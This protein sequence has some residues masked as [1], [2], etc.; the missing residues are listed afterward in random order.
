MNTVDSILHES[1]LTQPRRVHFSNGWVGHIPFSSWLVNILKPEVIV[2]LGT[3]CG[4]SYLAFC[5]AVQ[6]NNLDTKC[7]AVDTWKGDENAGYYGEEVFLE[8]SK[9]HDNQ[10]SAFSR[11]L[12]MTFDEGVAYFSDGS[13]DLL[14]IDGLHSYEAV[15]HDF[16]NWLPKVSPRGVILFHD[17]NVRER[18]FGVWKLW[19]ELKRDRP[20]IEFQHSHGLGALFVGKDFPENLQFLVQQFRDPDGYPMLKRLFAQLGQVISHQYEIGTLDAQIVSLNQSVAERDAQIGSL[21]QSVSERDAHIGSLNHAVAEL[22]AQIVGL[23]Q[24]RSWRV[25]APLRFLGRQCKRLL[26]I[27]RIMPRVIKSSG[28]PVTTFRKAVGVIRRE[29][30]V[31][32]RRRVS[33]IDNRISDGQFI[34]KL[35]GILPPKVDRYQAWLEVNQWNDRCRHQLEYRLEQCQH[36]LP[37]ISIITPVYNP[38]EKFLE[39]MIESVRNQVYDNWELC[40]ADDCSSNPSVLQVLRDAESLDP[41]IRV[42]YRTENGGISEATNT[43]AKM[44]SGKI[45]VLLDHDDQ[46]SPNA[47]AEVAVCFAERPEVDFLYTDHDKIDDAG[48]FSDPWFKPDWSPELLLSYCYVGHLK[49]IRKSLYEEIGGCRNDFDGA[50]DHDLALRAT[51]RARQVAHIPLILYHWAAAPGSTASSV[52]AKNYAHE[53]GRRAVVEALQRRGVVGN[54]RQPSW[55][56]GCLS[57]YEIEFPDNGHSV[58]IIIPTKNRIHLLKQCISSLD[59]TSYK[60]YSILIVDN[61]SDDPDVIDYL[62]HSCH[63]YITVGSPDGGFNFSYINNVAVKHAKSDL[64]LFLNNDTVVIEPKWLSQM[65]GYASIPGVGAVGARLLFK[66]GRIQ[67]CGVIH[68]FEDRALP[69]H[70]FKTCAGDDLGYMWLSAVARNCLAVTAACMLTPRSL[71]LETGGFDQDKLGTSY[72]DA[73][74]CMRLRDHGYRTVFCSQAELYHYEN[75]SRP[76]GGDL[77]ER[78]SFVGLHRCRKDPFFNP[79][80]SREFPPNLAIKPKHSY[81]GRCRR[82]RALMCGHN[83]NWEGAPGVQEQICVGLKQRGVIDPVVVSPCDGPRRKQYEQSMIGVRLIEFPLSQLPNMSIYDQALE[84][85]KIQFAEMGAEVIYA[86]TLLQ[87][88]V[89]EMANRLGIPT[90]WNIHESENPNSYFNFLLPEIRDRAYNC[91]AYPYRVVFVADATRNLWRHLDSKHNFMTIHNGLDEHSLERKGGKWSR[92]NARRSLNVDESE[93]VILLLGT[94]CERKG[95]QDLPLALGRLPKSTHEKLKCFIVGDRISQETANYSSGLAK[96]VGSLPVTLRRRTVIIPETADIAR[97]YKAADIFV[98]TSRIESYPLVI[99]EAMGYGLP[100]V[101]TPVYG[102]IEQVAP[103]LNSLIYDPGNIEQL[104]SHLE[105]LI[106]DNKLLSELAGNSRHV[107]EGLTNHDEMIDLYAEVFR[108]AFLTGARDGF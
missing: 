80:L 81:L 59:K 4:D 63:E 64:V 89:V 13:I 3:Y 29:G 61:Q 55:A 98:C 1:M 52:S 43:A 95:Q 107:L 82:F 37:K 35:D 51:E 53:A 21:N 65:V 5:Q 94:V 47:L 72:Q 75:S 71:F 100:I 14:H 20:S 12:R 79:N 34:E 103:N 54:V 70:A 108:E 7:Y 8:L 23:I 44:A 24:S 18:E 77:K 88:Y 66:D 16:E 50:Q 68:G 2:E 73:D 58:T 90:I 78:S 33:Q 105:R 69:D 84:R 49:A 19:E 22:D 36:K 17:I 106:V 102:I 15:K 40:L 30:L 42:V 57:I 11:L 25:T 62:N 32:L 74:Y 97:Y 76:S 31:G 104:A 41:R 27:L 26:R 60:N 87:W 91:F 6:E 45:F 10:Y 96:I 48:V 67:H 83:L 92:E 86:N 56:E 38:P 101:T 39:K 9:Y 46:L 28:N 93:T 99:L 85:L